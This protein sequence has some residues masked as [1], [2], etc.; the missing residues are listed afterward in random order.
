MP[1]YEIFQRHLDRVRTS[2]GKRKAKEKDA[3]EDIWSGYNLE[4]IPLEHAIALEFQKLLDEMGKPKV[5]GFN[6][7]YN[8]ERGKFDIKITGLRLSS[9]KTMSDDD[10]SS[11]ALCPHAVMSPLTG[12]GFMEKI[13]SRVEEFMRTYLVDRIEHPDNECEHK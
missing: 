4:V 3:L 7:K 12:M 5:L 11:H 10:T 8:S 9:G 13:D 1:S 2:Y 6:A